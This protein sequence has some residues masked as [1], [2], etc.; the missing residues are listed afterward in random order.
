MAAL[1]DDLAREYLDLVCATSPTAATRHGVHGRDAELDDLD[2]SGLDDHGR[3]LAKLEEQIRQA[4]GGDGPEGSPEVVE[5]EAD[6][7]ALLATVADDRFVHEI[8]RPWH[9]N[10]L[11]AV[12]TAVG[13]VVD[14]MI[15]EAT[16]HGERVHAA[17]RRLE[18]IPRLLDQARGLLDEPCP[19][20]WR[21]MASASARS[22]A[23][24]LTEGVPDWVEG[25][26]GADRAREAAGSAAR[27][28]GHCGVWLD[29]GSAGQFG[30]RALFTAGSG[31]L[32][33]RLQEVHHLGIS[34]EEVVTAGR[35]EITRMRAE[36]AEEAGRLGWQDWATGLAELRQRPLPGR[37]L[38]AYGRETHHLRRLVDGEGMV[39]VPDGDNLRIETTPRFLRRFSGL[40]AYIPAPTTGTGDGRLWVNTSEPAARDGHGRAMVPVLAAHEAYPGH[41]LRST[42]VRTLPSLTRRVARAATMA[43]GWALYA[44]GLAG[45]LG[46]LG[47]EGRLARLGMR[48][49]RAVRMV[50][51][52]ELHRERFTAEQATRVM[53][54]VA[55]VSEPVARQE[56]LRL[57]MNP[58]AGCTHLAGCLTLERLRVSSQ[59][60][61]RRGFTVRD[62]HDRVLA[63]GNTPPAVVA[64]TMEAAD[65][66]ELGGDE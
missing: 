23:A 64:R 63:Y 29:D 3:R 48:L 31:A 21:S 58:G 11:T 18:L 56:V 10:P 38:A 47:R 12:S 52:V 65:A 2:Q 17:T 6:R 14:L 5:A 59:Q 42:V 7:A 60:R 19:D 54:E 45:E 22:G 61:L 37:L 51:D 39:S 40:V 41:H 1:F 57:T 13:A 8:Q 50:V 20:A 30:S 43:D 28:L 36:L 53:T 46:A 49:L 66:W 9:R 15:H 34:P 26:E 24:L 35:S 55:R 62:F 25:A 16:P 33:Q 27:A 4:P 44:E 32:A